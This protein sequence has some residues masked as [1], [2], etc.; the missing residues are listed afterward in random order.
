[1]QRKFKLQKP[2]LHCIENPLSRTIHLL[3]GMSNMMLKALKPSPQT[4]LTSGPRC[5]HTPYTRYV[6]CGD[7]KPTLVFND[8]HESPELSNHGMTR[9]RPYGWPYQLLLSYRVYFSR[10]ALNPQ[11]L[12]M[13]IRPVKSE[14]II[15]LHWYLACIRSSVV[16]SWAPTEC[17][18][19]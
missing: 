11:G 2:F 7:A 5:L 18:R 16:M 14:R 15:M 8:N 10:Q 12:C 13:H 17:R 4:Q 3:H 6:F 1:M 19:K 9:L